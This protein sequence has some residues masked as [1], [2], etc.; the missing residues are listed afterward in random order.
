[1]HIL[2]LDQLI[3]TCGAQPIA[4]RDADAIRNQA[5]WSREHFCDEF[6]R[7]VAHGYAI[8]R[9]SYAVADAAMNRLYVFGYGNEDGVLPTY[10]W[11]VYRAFDDGEYR[12]YGDAEDVDPEQKYTRPQILELVAREQAKDG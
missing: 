6:S 4:E 3:R 7:R 2:L 5:G 9:L 12:H 11:D 8:G 10:S 1:M